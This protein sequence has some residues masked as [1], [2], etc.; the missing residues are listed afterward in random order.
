MN[1][2][3]N[4]LHLFKIFIMDFTY[5][6]YFNYYLKEFCN[7][8]ITNFP[9]YE[10]NI[11]ANYRELLENNK[12]KNDLYSKC[13]VSKVNDLMERICNS[14]TELFVAKNWFNEDTQVQGGLFLL[15]GV[16]FVSLW[17]SDYNNDKN[18]KAIWKYLKLLVLLGRKIIPNKD[19]ILEILNQV[20]GQVYAPSKVEKVLNND[21][22]DLDDAGNTPDIFGLGNLAGLASMAGIGNGEMPDLSSL[23]STLGNALSNIDMNEITKQ[24]E[25][26]QKAAE[27]KLNTD[28]DQTT[29]TNETT[30][31]DQTTDANETTDNDQTTDTN[32]TTDTNET[33][34]NDLS[35]TTTNLFTDLAKEMTETFDFKEL[36]SDKP[37]N[38]GEMFGKFLSGDNPAKLMGLVSK[39]GSKIQND[40]MNG[41]MNQNDLFKDAQKM[42]SGLKGN[43]NLKKQAQ[44]MAKSNPGLTQQMQQM[45]K[46]QQRQGGDR[47]SHIR[48]KLKAR[49]EAKQKAASENNK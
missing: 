27:E 37:T 19:E 15:E 22:D 39:F 48:N 41:N 5:L 7:E 28:N 38:M 45:Q 17:N 40:V 11:V 49:Y 3:N 31:N 14:D 42:M 20:D 35:S 30:D 8:I 21:N 9:N 13:F 46:Q 2:L 24:M 47:A 32:G 16:D 26:V 10:K 18:K 44:K 36:E 29:D 34:N 43:D 4:K 12:C 33:T 1:K 23:V 25:K 6:D